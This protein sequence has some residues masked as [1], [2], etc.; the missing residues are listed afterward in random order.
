[1]TT[2]QSNLI[3][4]R[5]T[6]KLMGATGV[7]ALV[8]WSDKPQS[9][10]M[11]Q[12]SSKVKADSLSCVARPQQTEGSYFADEKLNRSDIRTD[13]ITNVMKAYH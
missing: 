7:M 5:S 8:G 12:Y 9:W 1:M 10:F 11:G 4:R 3:S 2:Q 6:L 13:P